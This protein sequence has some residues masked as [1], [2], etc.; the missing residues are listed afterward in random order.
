M[1]LPPIKAESKIAACH[2]V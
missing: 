1:I 2:L